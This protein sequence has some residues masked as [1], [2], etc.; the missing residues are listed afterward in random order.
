MHKTSKFYNTLKHIVDSLVYIDKNN[1]LQTTL[2]TKPIST[3]V[4]MTD[5]LTPNISKIEFPL[6]KKFE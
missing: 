2:H 5:L 4:T 3:R 6:N 1:Q